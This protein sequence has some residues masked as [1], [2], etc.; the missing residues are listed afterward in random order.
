MVGRSL[1]TTTELTLGWNHE[2]P[3]GTGASRRRFRRALDLLSA[4]GFERLDEGRYDV[5]NVSNDAE[6]SD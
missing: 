5:V 1:F 2:V 6:I 3:C 4:A